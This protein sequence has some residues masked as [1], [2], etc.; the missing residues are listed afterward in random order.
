MRTQVPG[1]LPPLVREPVRAARPGPVARR[2]ASA[3]PTVVQSALGAGVAWIIARGLLGHRQPV[4]AA[5][6][7]IICLS[8][9][10]GGRGRQAVD[11]LAG[12]V[13]GVL[14]GDLAVH[15]V[16]HLVIGVG[17]LVVVGA[18]AVSLLAA[19]LLDA[20]PLAFIQAGAS[21]MFVVTLTGTGTPL[22]R[23]EDAAIGGLLGLFGSQVLFAPDP[24]ELVKAP[25][26][27][28]FDGL[29]DAVRLGAR[30]LRDGDPDRSDEAVR[31]VREVHVKI[32]NLAEA[33]DTSRKVTSRTLRGWRRRSPARH[34]DDG[35][36]TVD[37]LM[38]S[39]VLLLR[40]LHR[41]LRES[42][43]DPALEVGDLE[44][45]AD[46]IDAVGGYRLGERDDPGDIRPGDENTADLEQA[47][48][49]RIAYEAL[50][51]LVRW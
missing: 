5:T 23:L 26:R 6:A 11:L 30:A 51:V 33:R 50:I 36:D 25:L 16:R 18:V 10:T 37:T 8:A 27:D 48:H 12:V 13:A 7:A 22:T 15:L 38:A 28:V 32:G 46:A 1:H 20:R 42:G 41:H 34:L 35:L 43:E 17:T 21:A 14:V 29:A 47:P 45:L 9:G 39:V 2:L 19:A 44:R 31:R 40:G 3:W 24:V 49:L 4:F